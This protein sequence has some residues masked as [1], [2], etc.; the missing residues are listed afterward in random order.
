MIT[1]G[2]SPPARTNVAIA[3]FVAPWRHT[4][5]SLAAT[6]SD[7]GMFLASPE[8]VRIVTT[9]S[10]ESASPTDDTTPIASENGWVD[11]WSL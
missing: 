4:G 1:P 9:C 3:A 5:N 10:P 7:A 2:P 8:R 11:E 6:M